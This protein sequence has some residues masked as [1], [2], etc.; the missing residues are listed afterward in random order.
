LKT[1]NLQSPCKVIIPFLFHTP[2]SIPSPFFFL[3]LLFLLPFSFPL[4]QM[5]YFP[6]ILNDPQIPHINWKEIQMGDRIGLGA[7][8]CVYQGVW[9]PLDDKEPVDIAL[10]ELLFGIT[11]LNDNL[12]EFLV[13]IKLMRFFSHS[14][15]SFLNKNHFSLII[16]KQQCIKT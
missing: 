14:P 5:Y 15:P 4:T 6:D 8:G 3:P 16:C 11:E 12:Q 9:N 13:E 7:S 2:S 1:E 10:K